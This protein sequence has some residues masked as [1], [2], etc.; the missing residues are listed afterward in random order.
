[1]GNNNPIGFHV[2]LNFL[3]CVILIIHF[4]MSHVSV[5]MIIQIPTPLLLTC[6][7]WCKVKLSLSLIT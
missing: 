5:Y 2:Q 3:S 4:P 6:Y 7:K 1:V